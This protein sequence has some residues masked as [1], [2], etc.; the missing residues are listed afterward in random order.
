MEIRSRLSTRKRVQTEVGSKSMA[1]QS[2]KTECDIN[3][4][5]KKF[6]KTGILPD[7]IKQD[8]QYG[9]FS[10]V[11]SY[12]EAVNLVHKAHE[13]FDALS[14]KVRARFENDP[15][16]FLAFATDPKNGQEMVKMGLAT[17][18]PVVSAPKAP[19]AQKS[20]SEP[21]GSNE[22]PKAQ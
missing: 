14:A 5:M 21:K 8:P 9:D 2:F 18:T 3:H 20:G 12:H 13:Q 16:Q 19:P 17:P 11:P 10:D 4:I 15:A 6:E 1:K 7:L 22:T